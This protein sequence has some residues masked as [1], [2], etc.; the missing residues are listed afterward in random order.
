[1]REINN[2]IAPAL[3]LCAIG[4]VGQSQTLRPFA[5][6]DLR[7]E[8]SYPSTYGVTDLPCGDAEMAAGNGYQSLLY[9]RK[10]KSRDAASISVMLDRRQF[11]LDALRQMHSRADEQPTMIEVGKNVFY[12]YGRGGGGVSYPDEYFTT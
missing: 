10:G 6:S 8:L 9:V 7:F 12:Y 1:M 3:L 2:A 5:S 11:S 4:A